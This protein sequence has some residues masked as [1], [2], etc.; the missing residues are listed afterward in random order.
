MFN[1]ITVSDIPMSSMLN[2]EMNEFTFTIPKYV[3]GEGVENYR[4]L[5]GL[6]G[7]NVAIPT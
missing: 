4:V 5:G 6:F 3:Y 1:S 2:L 7:I